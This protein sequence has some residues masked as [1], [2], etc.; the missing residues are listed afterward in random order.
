M[1]DPT[2][3]AQAGLARGHLAH[4]L[5][6]VQAALHQELAFGLVDQLDRLRRRGF[7]VRHVD[8]FV[9]TDIETMLAGNAGNLGGRSHEDR[10]NDAR[11]RCFNGAA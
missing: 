10:N 9:A 8:D 2:R 7:A 1:A 6:R 5:V 4:E 11:F 3:R